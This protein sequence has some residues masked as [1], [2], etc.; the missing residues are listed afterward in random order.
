MPHKGS[1]QAYKQQ[2]L[3]ILRSLA[4]QSLIQT[5]TFRFLF[6]PYSIHARPAAQARSPSCCWSALLGLTPN[7]ET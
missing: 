2:Q 5:V 4:G 3:V 6:I 7:A 1:N